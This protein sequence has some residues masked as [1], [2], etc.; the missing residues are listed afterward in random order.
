MTH[1]SHEFGKACENAAAAF[2]QNRGTRV[3]ARNYRCRTGEIDLIVADH[4]VL[5]FVEVR[6]RA[7]STE[8]AIFSVDRKK[9]ARL[10]RVAAWFLVREEARIPPEIT[11]VRFDVVAVDRNGAVT[12]IPHAFFL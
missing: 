1:T 11:E 5:V 2:Y 6:G 7:Q 3:I 4:G 10:A 12:R 9:R 8:A